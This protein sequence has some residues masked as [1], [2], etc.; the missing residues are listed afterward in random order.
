[1][2]EEAGGGLTVRFTASGHLEM[3]WHLYMWGD[4]VEVLSPAPLPRW[5]SNTGGGISRRCRKWGMTHAW[6]AP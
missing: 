3:G 4:V 6:F 2:T 1:M 5:S